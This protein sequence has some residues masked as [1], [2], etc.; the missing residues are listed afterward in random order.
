MT[1]THGNSAEQALTRLVH[2]VVVGDGRV[3]A[4]E[5]Q[6]SDRAGDRSGCAYRARSRSPADHGSDGLAGIRRKARPLQGGAFVYSRQCP[7]V[8]RCGGPLDRNIVVL[9]EFWRIAFRRH[10]FTSRRSRQGSRLRRRVAASSV[11]ARRAR[12]AWSA[13]SVPIARMAISSATP[14]HDGRSGEPMEGSVWLMP[15]ATA[16]EP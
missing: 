9:A 5:H 10:Y 7:E 16:A 3:A 11:S 15:P 1:T 13:Q 2:C 14:H 4:C 6:G 12:V 8:N